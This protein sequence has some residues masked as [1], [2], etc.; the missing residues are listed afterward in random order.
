[1]KVILF[2]YSRGIISSR[3]IAQACEENVVFMALS[4]D[5]RPHFTTIAEFI[6]SMSEEI[7]SVFRDILTVCFAEAEKIEQSVRL[8][9]NRHRQQ[10]EATAEAGQREKE[11]RAIDNLQAKAKHLEEVVESVRRMLTAIEGK[12]GAIK[13]VVITAHSGFHS[14]ESVSKPF[15]QRKH[16]DPAGRY[17]VNSSAMMSI[18]GKVHWQSRQA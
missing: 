11:K 5:T 8:L 3:R 18:L 15:I 17:A 2:A 14:E 9:V 16:A 4:A 12:E 10:D 13:E 6:S 7:T 1:L